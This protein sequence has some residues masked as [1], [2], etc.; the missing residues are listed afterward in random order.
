MGVFGNYTKL[1][2]LT[3]VVAF[4]MFG[5]SGC[6]GNLSQYFSQLPGA[7]SL[8]PGGTPSPLGI[9]TPL[10][11]SSPSSSPDPTPSPSGGPI[12]CQ[13]F[14][15]TGSPVGTETGHGLISQLT[16]LPPGAPIA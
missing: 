3:T 6:S 8:T 14:G 15:E 5:A 16:Y 11:F 13:P 7:T 12:V 10:P 2:R 9:S 1:A 4:A